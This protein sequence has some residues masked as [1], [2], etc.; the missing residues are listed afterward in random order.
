MQQKVHAG[1]ERLYTE[2]EVNDTLQSAMWL[3]NQHFSLQLQQLADL[4]H[5]KNLALLSS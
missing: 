2:L 1:E 4:L 5:Q 3:T